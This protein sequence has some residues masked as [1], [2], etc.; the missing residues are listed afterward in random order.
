MPCR[1][2]TNN[3]A[4]ALP[5]GRRCADACLGLLL[6]LSALLPLPLQADPAEALQD[7]SLPA[8]NLN[9]ALL[10]FAD[11]SGYQLA[12]EVSLVQGLRSHPVNGRYSVSDALQLLLGDT[13]LSASIDNHKRI[14]LHAAVSNPAITLAPMVISAAGFEQ[15]IDDA[16]ASVTAIDREQLRDRPYRSVHDSTTLAPGVAVIGGINGEGS[17]IAIRGMEPEQTLIMVDSRR[18]SSR[19]A[20]PRGG[21][22]DLD[23]NWL[24]PLPAIERIEVIRG[25]MSSLHGADA[26]GGVIN[27]ITRDVAAEW[28]GDL[29]LSGTS[30]QDR[31]NGDKRQLDA[32][33]SG[34]LIDD[35]VSLQLWGFRKY[36]QEDSR[37]GGIQG[38][39]QQLLTTR[40]WFF[41]NGKQRL[42]L[43][44]N[45]ADQDYQ[46]RANRSGEGEDNRRNYQHESWTI[47]HYGQWDD[48]SSELQIY[49]ERIERDS[50]LSNSAIPTYATHD[51]IDA[52]AS[53][54]NPAHSVSVGAQWHRLASAK[55]DF[56]DLGNPASSW[57]KRRIDQWAA[58]VEDEWQL[59]HQLSLT[60]GLRLTHHA[61]YGDHWSPR[62]YLVWSA[63]PWTL[64]GGVGTG[65]KT[66]DI[67]EIEADTGSPQARGAILAYGNPS[68]KPE[69]STSYEMGLYYQ[70]PALHASATLF[71]NR[72]ENKIINTASYRFYDEQGELYGAN[73]Q[74][75]Q[76]QDPPDRDCPAWGTWLNLPGADIR[77]LELALDWQ[78]H[79]RWQLRGNYT[80]TDSH[81]RQ[82]QLSVTAPDGKRI[83]F[84]PG[85]FTGLSGNPLT[86]TPKHLATLLM[87][88][89]QSQK[90]SMYLRLNAESH[91][92]QISFGQGNRVRKQRASLATADLGGHW[93]MTPAVRLSA[94]LYNLGNSSRFSPAK[95]NDPEL[96]QYPEEGRRL[97]LSLQCTF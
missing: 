93:Q 24:P 89:Q 79:P 81:I 60:S 2:G 72:F 3:S 8:Q 38:A 35:A 71:H 80:Y 43:E 73:G 13:P 82:Q 18:I 12:Y 83:P 91:A 66:P 95:N 64:K 32:Y 90:M 70:R 57:G 87:H 5:C 14:V 33:L 20:N 46:R 45:R 77:G 76:P 51:V 7:F 84:S 40:L 29:W 47:A 36:R 17:G 16:P 22:G 53:F 94:A 9:Q 30:Q 15:H 10:K 54:Y 56:R 19:E 4:T 78:L 65:F 42:L 39:Q 31:D 1:I 74:S 28:T 62:A 50:P 52:K 25:P 75:C 23:S 68:L 67:R 58:F 37:D 6:W 59:H 21:G 49:R 63:G 92:T 41:P 69:E 27:V 34:P 88:W 55:S 96:Y 85:S 86:A 48:A 61:L 44:H 11:H 97:W 26:S